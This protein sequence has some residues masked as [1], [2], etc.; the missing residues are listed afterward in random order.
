MLL[1]TSLILILLSII[2]IIYNW[3]LNKNACFIGL[4]FF[5]VAIY[6]LTHYLT[7]YGKSAFWLALFFNTVSPFMLLSGPFFYFYIRGTLNDSQGL[8][9]VD[10]LHFIPAIVHFFG[11]STY[12]F[13]PFSY[14]KEVAQ[15][16]ID[17]FDVI[18]SIKVNL[19]F[20]YKFNFIFRLFHLF[21]YAVFSGFLLW[22]FSKS[23][24]NQIHIPKNQL[25][26]TYR[27]LVLLVILVL[28][29]VINF[30]I[31]TLFFIK[32]S[33][34]QLLQN[35]IIVNITTGITFTILAIGILFFPEILY[36]LPN[37]KNANLKRKFKRI[38]QMNIL[39]NEEDNEPFYELAS[40]IR[41]YLDEE[42]PFTNP[43]FSISDIALEMKV[44][45]HHV[46]YCINNI[47][48]MKFT[49]L[50]TELRVDYTK[51]LLQDTFHSNITI[52]GI[53]QM[54]GFNSRSSFYNAFKE[55]TGKTPIEFL[56]S[57]N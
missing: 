3:K 53:A 27:W 22:N 49:K 37:N 32:Y 33:G 51:K 50:R 17:N 1:F 12:L 54:A 57:I 26:V 36:G 28:F 18:K 16:I 43:N 23:K 2:L 29:L 42:K 9:R 8:K 34:N 56:N 31:L 41:T 39:Q 45:H 52:D 46:S 30:L 13:T 40:K 44:P 24:T 25:K 20:N 19:F 47:F 5:L 48:K 38:N 35:T 11:I 21:S 7:V 4:F 10:Y 14:K 15:L 6:G 55:V